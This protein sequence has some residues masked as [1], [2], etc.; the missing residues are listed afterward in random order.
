M[1]QSKNLIVSLFFFSPFNLEDR[2]QLSLLLDVSILQSSSMRICGLSGNIA[3]GKSTVVAQ[4]VEEGVSVID[5][6]EIAKEAVEKVKKE[7]AFHNRSLSRPRDPQTS[8]TTSTSTSLQQQ[9][10]WGH[11]RVV[12][13]F[14]SDD[15]LTPDGSIDREKLGALVFGD[16]SGTL[17]R[18]LNAATHLPITLSLLKSLLSRWLSCR[19]VVVV[20]MPLLY[21]TG[22]WVL[23]RPRVLVRCER[24]TQVRRV[25]ERDGLS[26]AAARSRVAA[27]AP[28][29]GKAARSHCVIDN[30]GSVEELREAAARVLV[31]GGKEGEGKKEEG[32]KRRRR[33]RRG[34]L[35]RGSLWH[36]L[37]APPALAAAVAVAVAL[38]VT[39][40]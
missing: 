26:E 15:I 40:R 10:T 17:R 20:D 4:L 34:L 13:A 35:F 14:G 5:C 12:S 36:A 30:D 31:W 24:E 21:E 2:G 33:E 11:R 16:A 25:M 29:E 37:L 7:M 8:S 38:C 23:T 1:R 18:K 3:S 19:L 9:G 39:L 28:P 32:K 27:Q 6:D 22:F